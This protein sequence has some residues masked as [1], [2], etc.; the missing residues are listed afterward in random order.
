MNIKKIIPI[1]A[2]IGIILIFSISKKED[3]S[4]NI[5]Q[6]ENQQIVNSD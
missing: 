2:V 6:G 3:V 1:V 4:I 5:V